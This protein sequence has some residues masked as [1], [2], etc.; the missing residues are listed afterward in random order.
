MLRSR[1]IYIIIIGVKVHIGALLLDTAVY[2]PVYP[3]SVFVAVNIYLALGKGHVNAADRVDYIRHT[4]EVYGGIFR[5]IK[6]EYG[7]EGL[8]R[9]LRTAL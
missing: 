6:S 2:S 3:S 8:Y 7:I 4:V 1:L 5:D 9:K